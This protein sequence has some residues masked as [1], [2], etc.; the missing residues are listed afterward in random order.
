[1]R[2]VRVGERVRIVALVRSILICGL[3]LGIGV[4]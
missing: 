4:G 2:I 1:M 3:V